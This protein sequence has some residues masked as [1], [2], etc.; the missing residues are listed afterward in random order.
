MAPGRLLDLDAILNPPLKRQKTDASTH[1]GRRGYDSQNDSGDDIFDDFETIATLP[2]PKQAPTQD[3]SLATQRRTAP[4]QL[5]NGA[6][7]HMASQSQNITQPTQ[8]LDTPVARLD[9]SGRKP[10]IVQVAASS[11][12]REPPRSSP[13]RFYG[14]PRPGGGILASAMAPPGTMYRLPH[15]VQK[16]VPEPVFIDISDD[17]GPQYRGDSSDEDAWRRR[18]TDIKPST[19]GTARSLLSTDTAAERV[20]ESPSVGLS[21]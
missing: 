11:P 14:A 6:S 17:D 4:Q 5:W 7:S 3:P 8:M 9:S 19:F 16:T 1:G 2:L 13:V 12:L 10:S 21:K 15:G 18:M 20:E